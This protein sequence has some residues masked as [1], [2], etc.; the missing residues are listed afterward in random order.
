M[1]DFEDSLND[2][3]KQSSVAAS[4]A[5]KALEGDLTKLIAAIHTDI[6]KLSPDVTDK[7][8]YDKLISVVKEATAK[9][10][11]LAQIVTRVKSLGKGAVELAKKLSGL[12]KI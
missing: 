5:D 3:D 11:N 6:D 8:T 9:N 4:N 10:E 12:V 2:L 7:E 1:S